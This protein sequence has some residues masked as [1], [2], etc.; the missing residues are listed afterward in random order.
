MRRSVAV[1]MIAATVL[2]TLPVPD[3]AVAST[4]QSQVKI[5]QEGILVEGMLYQIR[6]MGKY[7]QK[8]Y[9]LRDIVKALQGEIVWDKK[10]NTFNI[11]IIRQNIQLQL[12][13]NIVSVNG[14][15]SELSYPVKIEQQLAFVELESFMEAI[16]GDLTLLEDDS[17]VSISSF[18]RIAGLTGTPQWL[19]K[20]TLF[21][22]SNIEDQNLFYKFNVLSKVYEPIMLP[23][24]LEEELILSPKGD[25]AA[26]TNELGEIFVVS[27]KDGNTKK[28]TSDDQVKVEVQWS[29][30]GK[31]LYYLQGEK[32]NVVAEIEIESGK[33]TKIVDDKVDFKS[34]LRIS[35]DGKKILYSVVKN[36]VVKLDDNKDVSSIDTSG[37][38][39]QLYLFHLDKKEAKPEQLTTSADNKL[40]AN[41]MSNEE[42]TYLSS[43]ME[44][45][46]KM[47]E[48]ITINLSNKET[49]KV[50]SDINILQTIVTSPSN[51]LALGVDSAGQKIIYQINTEDG[52]K[53]K[54]LDVPDTT[55]QMIVSSSKNIAIIL[56]SEVE[57][58]LAFIHQGKIIPLSK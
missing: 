38:E 21:I 20:T 53:T 16:G 10:S 31:K 37:T 1:F 19:D 14:M 22:K 11:N 15:K 44:D 3:T 8:L 29:S 46:N 6:S 39:P 9:S 7:E 49:K 50:T 42:I 35:P 36:A 2:Q 13:S 51:I 26:Y 5:N 24:E 23:K 27:L 4:T 54:L 34:D 30:D 17:K 47:P 41:W 33:I 28:L 12:G 18:K 56:E 55:Y 57:D 52:Q 32:S 40:F 45:E 25:E 43:S 48:V 58:Q